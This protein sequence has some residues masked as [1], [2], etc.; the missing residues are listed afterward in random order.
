[1][2]DCYLSGEADWRRL[3]L[4][5]TAAINQPQQQQ[6]LN[7]KPLI[8]IINNDDDHDED[9][10]D[11]EPPPLAGLS[12]LA[13]SNPP[14]IKLMEEMIVEVSSVQKNAASSPV[15]PSS[16][17]KKSRIGGMKKGFLLSS[18]KKSSAS[19]KQNK[20]VT[21]ADYNVV[22]SL[23]SSSSSSRNS[24]E[25]P[26]LQESLH[27]QKES[28]SSSVLEL[29]KG[30]SHLMKALQDP[31]FVNALETIQRDPNQAKTIFQQDPTMAT[32]LQEFCG[33]MNDTLA[34]QQQQRYDPDQ[35]QVDK[36]LADP[37]IRAALLKPGMQQVMKECS[38]C[39][40]LYH[41]H[42]THNEFGPA[43]RLLLQHGLLQIKR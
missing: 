25:F 29:I 38:D 28:H 21:T 42:M 17:D 36:L 33:L 43:L 11:D 34:Q 40:G 22:T 13:P 31:S 37:S 23:S 4:V 24:L 14:T 10:D 15:N 9:Y 12:T 35:D 19:T 2:D 20:I 6:L 5:T 1:M 8:Q 27:R 41:T 7:A 3:T 16:C 26:H 30:K 18:N 32:L 39:P